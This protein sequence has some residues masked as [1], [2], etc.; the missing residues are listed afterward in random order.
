MVNQQ[1]SP[2]I[3]NC[4]FIN[5]FATRNGAA[6]MNSTNCSPV[7]TNCLFT[8]NTNGIG[9]DGVIF[10]FDSG[11]SLLINCTISGNSTRS[12][13][14][15]NFVNVNTQV[16]NSILWDN[17]N[18]S[19]FGDFTISHSI[20][21]GGF[22]ACTACPG[23]DGNVDPLFVDAANGD[24]TLRQCSPAID[25]GDN[26][27]FP[28]S[29]TT[30]LDRNPRVFNGGTV[31][32][33]AYEYQTPPVPPCT[34]PSC[35]VLDILALC[36]S[37]SGTIDNWMV[38]AGGP[39][40]VRITAEGAAGGS[41]N[42]GGGGGGGG[43]TG[44]QGGF[45]GT[46]SNVGGGGS[47]NLGANQNNTAG[48][49][50][51]GGQVIIELLG[52]AAF[53]ADFTPTQPECTNPVQGSLRI[54]LT[55]DNEGNTAGLEYAIVADNTFT[56]SPT[57]ADVTADPFDISSGFG[58]VG[59]AD[60]ETYTVRIRL[61]YNPGLFIDYIYTLTSP[62]TTRT[63]TGS[64]ST[65][66][67][68]NASGHI[69]IDRSISNGITNF[70][71]FTNAA[72]ITIGAVASVG[73]VGIF[74]G[75]TFQNN[76]AGHIRIDR[77]TLEGITN[78]GTFT[79]AAE[80]TIGAH[81]STGLNGLRNNGNFFNNAGGHIRI[82]RSTSSEIG[83]FSGGNFT[84]AGVIN[85]GAPGSTGAEG[86][87]NR[88]T[89]QNEACA[90]LFMNA[91]LSNTASFSNTGLF[92]VT[93]AGSHINSGLT[94]DGIIVYPQ[95]NLIHNVA[96]NEIIIAPTATTDCLSISPA[97]DL[98]ATVDFSILGV[99]ADANAMQ[100]AGTYAVAT[101]TFT[102]DNALLPTSTVFYVR[103]EDVANGCI[104]LVEWTVSSSGLP[105]T[106]YQDRDGDNYGDPANSQVFCDV[107]GTG[108]VA[109]NT[110]CNDNNA[111]EFPG[112][113]WYADTDGDNFGDPDTFI[114]ACTQPMGYV[115]NNTD[116]CPDIFNPD[117]SDSN[118]DGIGDACDPAELPAMNTW[119]LLLF[120]LV[121]LLLVWRKRGVFLF[122]KKES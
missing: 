98:G 111:D 109:N 52:A 82:D 112:Q 67:Q 43:Y 93:T 63:W 15:G 86:I 35:P 119:Q 69:H 114:E 88:A 101:N 94:N 121:V 51:E 58:T 122:D 41:G 96:N 99:F 20:V 26:N 106:C 46:S 59:D 40:K 75:S 53:T 50:N 32:L 36:P 65:D 72:D 103:I 97:F 45:A 105:V 68:N 83:N 17:S 27:A 14:L 79:N 12:A 16:Q 42:L 66:F 25:A 47:I 76:S 84:N 8:G 28:A 78:F 5:N 87:N 31:D 118:M 48:A 30:D 9:G 18:S 3:N 89:F 37:L 74:N 73:Q 100:P 44:G 61:K 49:N 29:I 110:D 115:A 1:S 7:F 70:G 54:D 77:F 4:T 57:F 102:P 39:Y 23:G 80:I 95:G 24:F 108:Y 13:V 33:G 85:L 38:P 22:G 92:T 81:E 62:T 71:T 117:Q 91:P 113:I 116:S 60:G 19:F 64:V 10:D 55:G 6:V 2:T 21:Q 56:G 107:C 120:G 104:R 34:S 90:Q 11:G